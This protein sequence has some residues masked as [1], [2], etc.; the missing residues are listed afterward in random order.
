ML[1]EFCERGTLE[2]AVRRGKFRTQEGKPNMVRTQD[3]VLTDVY[4]VRLF[5]N[6][7]LVLATCF[8]PLCCE[9]LWSSGGS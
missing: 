3:V 7:C 9:L 1:M 6:S 8:R 5:R 4:C 2:R